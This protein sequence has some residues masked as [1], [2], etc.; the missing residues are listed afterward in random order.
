MSRPSIR[1][2]DHGDRLYLRWYADDSLVW[3][4][5]LD[6]FKDWFPT[7]RDRSYNASTKTWSVPRYKR[8]RLGRWADQWFSADAQDWGD[9]DDGDAYSGSC[10][11]RSRPQQADLP[12][13]EA[14]YRVLHLLPSAPPSLVS[15][16]YRV[17]AQEQHP[18]HGGSNEAMAAINEAVKVVREHQHGRAG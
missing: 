6:S 18:D 16:A 15:A 1:I 8:D 10:R 13:V 7:H 12:A 17:L 9:E 3:H 2:I 5:I 4:Q 11:D 14:A